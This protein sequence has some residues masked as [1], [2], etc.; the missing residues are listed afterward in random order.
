MWEIA[1]VSRPSPPAWASSPLLNQACTT[2]QPW[3]IAKR[4]SVTTN[5]YGVTI[6]TLPMARL[7]RAH[8]AHRRTPGRDP[9]VPGQNTECVAAG[10]RCIV[11]ALIP[12]SGTRSS[13][14]RDFLPVKVRLPHA[15][16]H[17]KSLMDIVRTH[18]C[19]VSGPPLLA[20][21]LLSRPSSAEILSTSARVEVAPS[22]CIA[23]HEHPPLLF[24][25]STSMPFSVST[26]RIA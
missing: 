4:R 24:E 16:A 13:A 18:I 22:P 3:L 12:S 15:P 21:A 14:T 26:T 6:S 10:Q 8:R 2:R 23:L 9:A 20:L 11:P 19:L 1:R 25:P 7:R 5:Q 17:A